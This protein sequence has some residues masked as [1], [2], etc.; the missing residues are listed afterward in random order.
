MNFFQLSQNENDPFVSAI[1]I[2]VVDGSTLVKCI[3]DL[4]NII[5][6]KNNGHH[7]DTTEEEKYHYSNNHLFCNHR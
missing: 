1:Y 5:V 6:E 3:S 4:Q 2:E 7:P